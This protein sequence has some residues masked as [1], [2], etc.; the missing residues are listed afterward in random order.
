MLHNEPDGLPAFL[1]SSLLDKKQ[2]EK[3]DNQLCALSL[4]RRKILL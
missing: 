4:I 1:C 2:I 3:I